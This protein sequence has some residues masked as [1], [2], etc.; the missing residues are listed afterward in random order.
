MIRSDKYKNKNRRVNWG[1][2]P[3]FWG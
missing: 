3:C 1:R 2:P